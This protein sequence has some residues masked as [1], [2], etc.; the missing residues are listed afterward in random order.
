M[1]PYDEQRGRGC[2]TRS[3]SVARRL[4]LNVPEH[5]DEIETAASVGGADVVIA[6]SPLGYVLSEA[7][8]VDF[9]VK[10]VAVSVPI[11]SAGLSAG[12]PAVAA[13]PDLAVV[14]SSPSPPA[15]D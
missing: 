14:H 15:M 4:H 7:V 5:L 9:G 13:A 11:V 10:C 3:R 12:V 6:G 8:Q 1:T 2:A